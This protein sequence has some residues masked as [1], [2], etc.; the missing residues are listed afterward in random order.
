[1]REQR[2][3]RADERRLERMEELFVVF[4][5]WEMYLSQIYLLH[6]RRHRGLLAPSQVEELV[7]KLDGLEKGD[8]HRLSMLLRLHFPELA[9]ENAAV[10]SARAA[11]V[12]FFDTSQ[13]SNVEAFIQAQEHFEKV[14]DDFKS[15]IAEL[16]QLTNA[17]AS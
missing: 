11:I 8:V 17:R 13:P 16:P 5:R 7:L 3:L 2:Q 14:A 12:P 4:Q 1:L 15:A 6:L 10:Q 9:T